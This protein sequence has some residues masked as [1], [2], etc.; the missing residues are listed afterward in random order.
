M[1]YIHVVILFSLITSDVEH[2]FMFTFSH[3]DFYF[4]EF[5]SFA[6]FSDG[7]LVGL[8]GGGVAYFIEISYL[9]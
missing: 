6:H 3:L 2:L 7:F 1:S 9:E 8:G 4:H 5:L